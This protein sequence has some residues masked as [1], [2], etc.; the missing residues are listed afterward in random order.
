MNRILIWEATGSAGISQPV[1]YIY[2]IQEVKKEIY[3]ITH[4]ITH[5]S[6]VKKWTVKNLLK[7]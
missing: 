6:E 3:F 4:L 2:E 5:G 1:L 7:E